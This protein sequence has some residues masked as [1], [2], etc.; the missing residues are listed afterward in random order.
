MQHSIFRVINLKKY[1]KI[2]ILF[3][4]II[5]MICSGLWAVFTFAYANSAEGGVTYANQT[6]RNNNGNTVGGNPNIKELNQWVIYSN[7]KENV[8]DDNIVYL[9]NGSKNGPASLYR[10]DKIPSLSSIMENAISNTQDCRPIQGSKAKILNRK[11]GVDVNINWFLV[12]VLTGNCKGR[13]GWV[14]EAEI[15]LN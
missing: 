10:A 1:L 4:T 3:L 5:S 7:G 2:I 11:A 12:K 8:D 6:I 13:I 9:S 14:S 15:R